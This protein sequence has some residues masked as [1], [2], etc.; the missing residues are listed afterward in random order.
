[1]RDTAVP[2]EQGQGKLACAGT[3][4]PNVTGTRE[5]STGRESSRTPGEQEWGQGSPVHTGK[6]LG[7]PMAW[8]WGKGTLVH[9]GRGLGTLMASEWG[10]GTL[11]MQGRD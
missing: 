1:M 8:E 9:A 7:M 6:G 3:E 10:Q 2:Q 4:D 5:P 11:H